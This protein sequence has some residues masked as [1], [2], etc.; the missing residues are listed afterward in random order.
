MNLEK[1]SELVHNAY[2]ETCEKL[3]WEVKPENQIPYSELVEDSK[4]LDRASVRAVLKGI[5][6]AKLQ[7]AEAQNEILVEQLLPFGNQVYST[8]HKEWLYW[9]NIDGDLLAGEG[10]LVICSFRLNEGK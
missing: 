1:L 6:Y 4:E 7:E 9:K 2:L 10:N 3:G 8:D 5:G